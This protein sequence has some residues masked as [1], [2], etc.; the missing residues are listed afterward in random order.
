MTRN[1]YADSLFAKSA[2]VSRL[3]PATTQKAAIEAARD[4]GV[5]IRRDRDAPSGFEVYPIGSPERATYAECPREALFLAEAIA[6][7]MAQNRLSLVGRAT[8]KSVSAVLVRRAGAAY[9][10]KPGAIETTFHDAIPA[11]NG[12]SR[13]YDATPYLKRPLAEIAASWACA[14]EAAADD[15]KSLAESEGRTERTH[16]I[17]GRNA[18]GNSYVYA[19]G[20][21]PELTSW[22]EDKAEAVTFTYRD[23]ARVAAMIEEYQDGTRDLERGFYNVRPVKAT[24]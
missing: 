10:L 14:V 8:L 3:Y 2:A 6:E 17:T 5:M 12:G 16:V 19:L 24:Q 7:D 9:G 4:L 15:A 23:A 18:D 20:K 1:A 21:S 13:D 22:T 11:F